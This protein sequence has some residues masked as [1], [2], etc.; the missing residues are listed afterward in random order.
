MNSLRDLVDEASSRLAKKAP[1]P[2]LSQAKARLHEILI[3]AGK[4]GIEDHV[5]A[6]IRSRGDFLEVETQWGCRGSVQSEEVEIPLAVIDADDP[7]AEARL[8]G[9]RDRIAKAATLVRE[10]RRELEEAENDLLSARLELYEEC[11]EIDDAPPIGK[12]APDW[13]G[14]IDIL[15]EARNASRLNCTCGSADER[16]AWEGMA[17]IATNAIRHVMEIRDHDCD[18]STSEESVAVIGKEWQILWASAA[19]LSD[20]VDKHGL[21][22]G[23]RLYAARDVRAAVEEIRSA[24]SGRP[25]VSEAKTRDDLRGIAL[26]Q[27]A[28]L[29][30]VMRL[31]EDFRR[32][33]R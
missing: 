1:E 3:A 24:A 28:M 17:G 21:R 2:D 5:L 18:R 26:A 7:I 19:P 29:A 8:W 4:P 11:G 16:Q 27:S 33:V 30:K 20:I 6:A 12:D 14:L 10:H 23:D 32:I 15:A 25:S 22:I 9:I 31:C 13:A